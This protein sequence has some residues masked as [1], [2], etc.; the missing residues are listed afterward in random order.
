[1]DNLQLFI[2]LLSIICVSLI[3]VVFAQYMCIRELQGQVATDPLTGLLNRRAF[4]S[5]LGRLIKLLPVSDDH[6]HG[7]LDSLAL[8]FIDLDHFKRINDTFGHDVG[9]EVLKRVSACIQETLRDSD[10]VCRWGGEEIVVALPGLSNSGAI[11]VAEKVRKAID[12][13]TFSTTE[14]RVTISVGVAAT[15]LRMSQ[16]ELITQADQAVY[17]AK[18]NGRNRVVMH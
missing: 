17:K 16:S 15:V 3:F 7:S 18:V 8:F 6:R 12:R 9:D 5:A 13:L 1:M 2:V 14:L 4:E 11:K 10:L